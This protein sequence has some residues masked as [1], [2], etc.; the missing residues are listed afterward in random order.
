MNKIIFLIYARLDRFVT[1]AEE[2]KEFFIKSSTEHELN[3]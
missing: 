3:I 1:A 2:E